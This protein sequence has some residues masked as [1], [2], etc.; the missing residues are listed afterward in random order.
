MTTLSS[1]GYVAHVHCFRY[2]NG[3]MCPTEIG[4]VQVLPLG[5]PDKE[6]KTLLVTVNNSDLKMHLA[7]WRA[8]VVMSD[9]ISKLPPN[10]IG[11]YTR[12]EAEQRVRD[13]I[14]R[15][16]LVAAK[17]LEEKSYFRGLGLHVVELKSEVMPQCPKYKDLPSHFK[18][19]PLRLWHSG[20]HNDCCSRAIALGFAR[21]IEWQV[22]ADEPKCASEPWWDDFME[23]IDCM[24]TKQTSLS[25]PKQ[26]EPNLSEPQVIVL[27]VK[28]PMKVIIN[29]L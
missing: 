16:S 29:V 25:Q 14:P 18:H 10:F 23:P 15:G 9:K 20:N 19:L 7:D 22:L 1:I 6:R 26:D 8:N 11:E 3:R 13:F 17:G 2:E 28:C 24:E 4:V 27:N 12:A 21:F 5:I